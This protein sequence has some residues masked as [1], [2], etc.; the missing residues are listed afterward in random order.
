[1]KSLLSRTA[2][3]ALAVL[4][5][6]LVYAKPG[7]ATTAAMLT[8]EDLITSSRVILLGEVLSTKSQHDLNHATI[9]TYVKVRVSEVL[10]GQ[11]VNEQ[12]VFKQM[13]GTVGEETAVVFGAPDYTQGERVLLFL[14]TAG[15]GTLRVAHLFQGKYDVVAD[16]QGGKRRVERRVDRGEVNIMGEVESPFITNRASL[17]RFSKKI[18]K[19]LRSRQEVVAIYDERYAD[20]PI[21]EVPPDYIDDAASDSVGVRPSYALMKARWF[22][23]DSGQ[24]ARFMV[25][26]NG[27]PIAGGGGTEINQA[28]AAWSTTANS[29]L[30]IQNAGSTGAG[31][32]QKDGV[33]AISY[34]DPLDQM[35]DPVGCGG[36]LGL[37]GYVSAGSP[38]KTIGSQTFYKI[39]EADVVFNRNFSCFLG[40]SANLAEVACHEIGHAIG[41]DH[42]PDQS[43]IMYATAHG[44]G[45]GARLGSDDAA[46]ASFLYPG[47]RGGTPPPSSSNNAAF[48]AQSVPASMVAGQNYSVSVT[49]RNSGTTTWNTTSYKLGSQSPANNLN[50][51]VNRLAV[52]VPVA[53]G[54]QT[55]FTFTVRAP[56]TPGTYN[57]QWQV[58]ENSAGFFGALSP[59]VAVSVGSGG[60]APAGNNAAYVTQSVP[61]TLAPGQTFGAQITMRNTGT[62]TWNTTSYKLGSQNPANNMNWG[63][64]RAPLA[65][66]V[67]P[68][69]EVTFSLSL[70]APLT[71]GTYNFQWQMVETSAGF[72][73]A[74][75]PNVVVT[76]SSTTAGPLAITTASIPYPTRGVFYSAQLAAAGG[77]PSY[78]WFVAAGSLP[79]GLSLNSSTGVLSGTPTLA[80]TYYFTLG[81]RDRNNATATRAFKTLVR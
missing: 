42:S 79:P 75:A 47:T 35:S 14:D 26:P 69:G 53:P 8:D 21:V 17:R 34:N 46:A 1:M 6:V 12:I 49:M 10:K 19:T 11:L 40:V 74:T 18:K 23:P 41:F 44:G 45:R 57:F 64:N 77:Q 37:G 9:Y 56:S 2:L 66:T 36:T 80:S 31:G 51:G 39:Y 30:L 54:S 25:N 29:T 33:S 50:W 16:E 32:W 24:P 4:I 20:T 38:T 7:A 61:A 28:M 5:A 72:F 59:A 3:Q 60:P 15:D 73:G 58:V 55:T 68:G 43:A 81:V 48:V 13:G 67:A 27:S 63:F 76:V 78:T 62:A 65:A 22:E 70:K 52:P 71:P